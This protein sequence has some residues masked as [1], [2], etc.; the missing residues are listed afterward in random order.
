MMMMTTQAI[1]LCIF[2]VA[3]LFFS[4]AILRHETCTPGRELAIQVRWQ[5]STEG[6]NHQ[7]STSPKYHRIRLSPGMIGEGLKTRLR[8]APQ[9]SVGC[10]SLNRH[11]SAAPTPTHVV[12]VAADRDAQ[13]QD[14]EQQHHEQ[15]P[16]GEPGPRRFCCRHG[17]GH[18]PIAGWFIRHGHRLRAAQA[19]AK[20][21]AEP[22][23]QNLKLDDDNGLPCVLEVQLGY[24]QAATQGR[25]RS[26]CKSNSQSGEVSATKGEVSA[27]HKKV[28]VDQ[29]KSECGPKTK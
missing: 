1:S 21:E 14:R 11:R 26:E 15:G 22:R 7:A 19:I 17:R 18:R 6:S 12:Q 27:A 9:R 24:I 29:N 25:I 23:L 2:F 4:D 8:H 28:S 20:L 3:L 16:K 10:R 5:S 13:E